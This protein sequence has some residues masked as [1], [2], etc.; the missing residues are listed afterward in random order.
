MSTNNSG[1]LGK[2]LLLRKALSTGINRTE[3]IQVLGGPSLNTPLT[4][5]LPADILGGEQNFDLYPYSITNAKKLLSQAGYK[6]GLTL[7][8][9]YRPSS[10][11]SR[12][13]FQVV[14]SDLKKIGVT[15]KGV[16]S[17][18]ADFYTKYLQVPRSPTVGP[19]T[20]PWPAGA[21]TGTA[22]R[23]CRSS[24][25]CTWRRAPTRPWVATSASTTARP[26]TP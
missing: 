21:P 3:L 23:R 24:T 4:H 9:L 10:E 25:R 22:T 16:P 14:Q 17:P 18:D 7:K 26:P 11:G 5:V 2:N 15:V 20:C 6:N 19:G 1:A 13:S 8:F 12:N